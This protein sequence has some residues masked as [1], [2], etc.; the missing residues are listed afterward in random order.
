MDYSAFTL[1]W[2]AFGRRP[3]R[4]MPAADICHL[5]WTTDLLDFRMLP[6]MSRRGPLVWTLHD[7][8]P[9]TGGCHYDDE[10]GRFTA[11]CG[12]CPILPSSNLADVST[13]RARAQGT[14]AGRAARRLPAHRHA[15]PLDGRGSTAQPSRRFEVSVIPNG[16][17]TALYCP[18]DRGAVRARLGLAP[19]DRALLFVADNLSDG[20]KGWAKLTDAINRLGSVPNLRI[21][22]LGR[23]DTASMTGPRYLHLGRL[24]RAGGDPRRVQCGRRVRRAVVAG[25]FP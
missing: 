3:V 21:M 11:A 17:D 24:Q 10:C 12:A 13:P 1:D 15:Q 5:H 19:G 25:Q 2:T 6:A 9:F 8:N 23:G 7:M 4:Q 20:R 22:T 14:R 18:V 16:I